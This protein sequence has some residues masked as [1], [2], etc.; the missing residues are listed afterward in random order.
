[1]K[2]LIKYLELLTCIPG[3]IASALIIPLVVATC[4]EVF[5]R[6]LFGNPT[7]WAYEFGYLL[8]GFHFLLGGALTL[9][10]Q[11]H[12]RIDIF[13]NKMKKKTKS[14]VDLTLYLFLIIPCFSILSL[15]LLEHAQSSFLSG[16]TTG[17]SAWNPLIWPMHFVI[18]VSFFILLLQVVAECLKAIISIKEN[19]EKI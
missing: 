14:I 6:Y 1:L 17:Q 4:Y 11:S 16:E 5:S 7:I 18:F 2:K 15:R 12:I 13:Y 3:Y 10:K 19:K 8:M 9:K